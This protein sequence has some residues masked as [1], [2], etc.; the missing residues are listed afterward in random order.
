MLVRCLEPSKKRDIFLNGEVFFFL[1]YPLMGDPIPLYFRSLGLG[2]LFTG[3]YEEA[4]A[5][6][7]KGLQMAP[8]DILTHQGLASAYGQAG[9]LKEAR[10]EVEEVLRINPKACIRPGSGG[11]KNPAD[12]ERFTDGLRKAGLPDYPPRPG[13]R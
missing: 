10:A 4:I 7:K 12:Q 11:Y 9:R 5:A 2:S 13:S 8:D 6:Y 1:T 3:R